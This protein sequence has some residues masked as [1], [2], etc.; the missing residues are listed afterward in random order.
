MTGEKLGYNWIADYPDT[1]WPTC[2]FEVLKHNEAR[3][4]KMTDHCKTADPPAGNVLDR[5]C[6][7]VEVSFGCILLA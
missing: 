3:E 1:I 7:L 4:G 5:R 6:D 2:F